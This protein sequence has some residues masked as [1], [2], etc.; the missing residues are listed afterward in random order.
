LPQTKP[1]TPRLRPIKLHRHLPRLLLDHRRFDL[2]HHMHLARLAVEAQGEPFLALGDG[3]RLG[4]HGALH[5]GDTLGLFW[6]R[7]SR[8]IAVLGCDH[9]LMQT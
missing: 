2:A 7:G 5:A 1:K 4:A 9:Q 6:G 8:R 3:H